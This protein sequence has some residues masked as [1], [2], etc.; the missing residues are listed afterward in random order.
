MKSNA[1]IRVPATVSPLRSQKFIVR[2]KP[3]EPGGKVDLFAG[4]DR[5]SRNLFKKAR[6]SRA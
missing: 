4:N 5:P 2:V 6:N 3:V 1:K